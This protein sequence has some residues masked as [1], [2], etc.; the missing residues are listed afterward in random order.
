LCNASFDVK[1]MKAQLERAIK[2]TEATLLVVA[3]AA[4]PEDAVDGRAGSV[5]FPPLAA[6]A[7]SIDVTRSPTFTDV[8]WGDCESI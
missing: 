8:S 4:D 2:K 6:S 3:V 1:L 7:T 5:L